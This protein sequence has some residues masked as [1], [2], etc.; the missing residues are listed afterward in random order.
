M[1]CHD[2]DHYHNGDETAVYDEDGNDHQYDECDE[3]A[4]PKLVKTMT[5]PTVFDVVTT[6]TESLFV[7]AWMGGYDAPSYAAFRTRAE[8]IHQASVWWLTADKDEDQID[9]LSLNTT[10]LAMERIAGYDEDEDTPLQYCKYC[11]TTHAE[12]EFAD[13][14]DGRMVCGRCGGTS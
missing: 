1:T 6:D 12:W 7:V 3:P 4:D 13:T 9:I 2:P 14:C 11:Y 8:A 5:T 10:T